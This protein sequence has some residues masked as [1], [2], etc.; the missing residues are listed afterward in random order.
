M[1]HYGVKGMKWGVRRKK[2]Y[3][4]VKS[5]RK[6]YKAAKNQYKK[7]YKK[8]YNYS[9]SPKLTKAGKAKRDALW[10]NATASA[11]NAN[12]AKE[13]YK[14]TRENYKNSNYARSPKANRAILYGSAAVATAGIAAA[15][16]LA[17]PSNVAKGKKVVDSIITSAKLA[18][19]HAIVDGKRTKI[20]YL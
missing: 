4:Q 7:D 15:M 8:A 5:T 18:G 3:A 9:K 14:S 17:S 2:A 12:A 13:K 6:N 16:I 20:D 19:G 10:D 11:K 1:Y